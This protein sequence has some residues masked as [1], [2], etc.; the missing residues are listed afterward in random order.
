MYNIRRCVYW[1]GKHIMSNITDGISEE[2]RQARK[3]KGLGLDA[4][5]A[6]IC[7]STCYLRAIENAE[8]DKLPARTFA[9]GFVRSFAQAVGLDANSI[10]TKFKEETCQDEEPL[11]SSDTA[12]VK[13]PKK[14]SIWA[15]TLG[16]AVGI[17]MTWGLLSVTGTMSSSMIAEN[18]SAEQQPV[19]L[20]SATLDTDEPLKVVATD[21]SLA[22]VPQEA[23]PLYIHPT[24]QRIQTQSSI[25]PAAY[26]DTPMITEPGLN[27]DI[28][29]E[30]E[31][32]TWLKIADESGTELWEGVLR[33]GETYRPEVPK[34][35]VLTTSNA[36]GIKVTIE[37]TELGSFGARG[38][39]VTE[40]AL[41]SDD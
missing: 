19:Q 4:I 36:G 7:V 11:V 8:F 37:G 28:L 1:D 14:Q 20:A 32:D 30:A 41:K 6:D 24:P 27:G 21:I 34:N 33:S 13:A 31:E 18:Q 38:E 17:A 10:V 35:I 40:L 5:A 29:F 25:F 9:V 16:G 22:T 12:I 39:V 3:K 23:E 15:P 26:A 2:I